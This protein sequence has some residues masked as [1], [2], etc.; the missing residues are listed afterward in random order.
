[1]LAVGDINGKVVTRPS[2]SYLPEIKLVIAFPPRVIITG[3][4]LYIW[5][6]RG[7]V[8]KNAFPKKTWQH[9]SI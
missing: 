8:K 2:V 4:H 5:E 1:M 6:E 9:L 3:S 7:I